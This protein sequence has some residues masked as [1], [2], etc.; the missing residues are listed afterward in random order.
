MPSLG[1]GADVPAQAATQT[2]GEEAPGGNSPE[3]MRAMQAATE[4]LQKAAEHLERVAEQLESTVERM[5]T[6]A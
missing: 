5:T 6:L 4:A 2:T 1:A 3:V